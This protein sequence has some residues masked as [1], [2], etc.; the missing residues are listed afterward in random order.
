MPWEKPDCIFRIPP[1][2]KVNPTQKLLD[3]YS[4]EV[5]RS[6]R[7]YAF[8]LSLRGRELPQSLQINPKKTY[9]YRNINGII[10]E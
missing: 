4:S 7:G 9:F 6:V 5:K 3:L 10:T 2:R 8:L 1:P